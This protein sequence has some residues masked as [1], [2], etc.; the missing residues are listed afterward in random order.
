[1]SNS[2]APSRAE[3]TMA[4]STGT[5]SSRISPL[6]HSS[7][8]T[9]KAAATSDTAW[10]LPRYCT[11]MEERDTLPFTGQQPT[12]PAPRLAAAKASSS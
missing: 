10:V 9:I 11:F 4:V 2:T 6:P 12:M 3:M 7:T 5:G 1:M 8:P